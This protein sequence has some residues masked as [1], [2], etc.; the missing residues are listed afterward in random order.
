[1]TATSALT[2]KYYTT[3]NKCKVSFEETKLAYEVC[4]EDYF[5]N[6]APEAV[7]RKAVLR[8]PGLVPH[9]A[10]LQAVTHQAVTQGQLAM[11][12]SAVQ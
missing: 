3:L 12:T 1:M 2:T 11:V 5:E 10:V 8:I 4:M 7:I 9:Q 6:D